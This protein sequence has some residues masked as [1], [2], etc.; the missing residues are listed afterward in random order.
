MALKE[1]INKAFESSVGGSSSEISQLSEDLAKA[2]R[3]Y[4][5]ELTFRVESLTGDTILATGAVVTNTGVN[6]LPVK[7]SFTVSSDNPKLPTDQSNALVSVVKV[8]ENQNKSLSG[9]S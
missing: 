3:D 9:V 4:I 1:D 5:G 2:S 8:D 7:I 6:T